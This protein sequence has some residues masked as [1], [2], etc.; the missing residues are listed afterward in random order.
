MVHLLDLVT[1]TLVD[2]SNVDYTPTMLI[3]WYNMGCREIVKLAPD[4]NTVTEV[5]RLAIGANQVAPAGA[6]QLLDVTRNMGI[7]GVTVGKG[8][9]KTIQAS[10]SIYDRSWSVLA[11]QAAE[12]LNWAPD[13]PLSYWVNPPSDGTNYVEISFSKVPNQ[14]IWDGGGVWESELVGVTDKYVNALLNYILFAAYMKDSDYPGNEARCQ[15]YWNLFL[16]DVGQAER[17]LAQ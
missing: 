15:K 7:D 12:V 13:D 11:N 16:A 17:A 14:I 10:L 3:Y 4:A 2:T 9:T 8:I 6:I 1:E 5:V